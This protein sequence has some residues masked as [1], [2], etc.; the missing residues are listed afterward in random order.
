M[1]E[2]W[3]QLG[4]ALDE[5]SILCDGGAGIGVFLL[6][7]VDATGCIGIGVEQDPGPLDSRHLIQR[8]LHEDGWNGRVSSHVGKMHDIESLEGTTHYFEYRGYKATL[9]DYLNFRQGS[10]A[11]QDVE[12]WERLFSTSSL[13]VWSSTKASPTILARLAE[14]SRAIRLGLR[15]FRCVKSASL[16]FSNNTYTVFTYV[17]LPTSRQLDVPK[18]IPE[19]QVKEMI[20]FARLQTPGQPLAYSVTP[21]QLPGG[22]E[23]NPYY[24]KTAGRWQIFGGSGLTILTRGVSVAPGNWI[25]FR[26]GSPAVK[27]AILFG[28]A[29]LPDG[30]NLVACVWDPDA[31]RTFFVPYATIIGKMIGDDDYAP[32]TL[33]SSRL[34]E[35][36]KEKLTIEDATETPRRSARKQEQSAKSIIEKEALAKT[37]IKARRRAEGTTLLA[38][39]R[40][41]LRISLILSLP[42]PYTRTHCLSLSLS[43][44]RSLFPTL[45]SLLFHTYTRMCT[46]RL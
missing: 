16:R 45:F 15:A 19:G 4:C 2:L 31:D 39:L 3:R 34:K 8:A 42:L 28:T 32:I 38:R 23:K 35:L 12:V 30:S 6:W 25:N 1:L 29:R 17:R 13:L 41:A 18:E 21:D 37:E 44:A 9:P 10:T 40:H 7:A 27:E 46:Q 11:A 36:I 22:I 33:T 43:T 20:T 26:L 24:R 14:T 5:L